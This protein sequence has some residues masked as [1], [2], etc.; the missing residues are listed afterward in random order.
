MAYRAGKMAKVFLLAWYRKT[1]GSKKES[2][3]PWQHSDC[4]PSPP[5]TPWPCVTPSFLL[6]SGPD[7]QGCAW[8]D[9]SQLFA[10][11]NKDHK[12]ISDWVL[13]ELMAD[14]CFKSWG[15]LNT[16]QNFDQVSTTLPHK[17]WAAQEPFESLCVLAVARD[18]PSLP[19]GNLCTSYVKRCWYRSL[20]SD[21]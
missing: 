21:C 3:L 11:T 4:S 6:W 10:K 20:V 1:Q 12:S 2:L 13:K 5:R 9:N 7:A 14:A 15:Q 19:V 8:A 17:W 18:L 16:C